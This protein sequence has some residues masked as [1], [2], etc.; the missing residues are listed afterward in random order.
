[1]QPGSL[2]WLVVGDL[3]AIRDQLEGLDF[4]S[5]EIWNDAGEPVE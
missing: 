5:I 2:T 3:D 1:V 4:T